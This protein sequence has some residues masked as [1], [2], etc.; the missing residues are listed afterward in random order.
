M[1]LQ[2]G[3]HDSGPGDHDDFSGMNERE[4]LLPQLGKDKIIYVDFSLLIIN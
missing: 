4:Q 2:P 3:A 1:P